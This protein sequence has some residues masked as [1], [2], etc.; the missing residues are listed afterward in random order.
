MEVKDVKALI[1]GGN[2]LDVSSTETEGNVTT[3]RFEGTIDSPVYGT[4]DASLIEITVEENVDSE[5]E[6][7]FRLLLSGSLRRQSLCV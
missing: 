5:T 1:Y 2:L 4:Q 7:F 6:K 3:Y